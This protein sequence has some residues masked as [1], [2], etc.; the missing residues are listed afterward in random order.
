MGLQMKNFCQ[1]ILFATTNMVQL[2]L[3]LDGGKDHKR[4]ELPFVFQR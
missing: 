3:K 2:D 1:T 4:P